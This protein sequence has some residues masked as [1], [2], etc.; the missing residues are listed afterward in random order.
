MLRGWLRNIGGKVAIVCALAL[1]GA[2]AP[3][4]AHDAW[5]KA[6][7]VKALQKNKHKQV[8]RR[9]AAAV[10]PHKDARFAAL[11][12][13][14]DRNVVLYEKNAQAIRYP[15]SLAKMMTLYLVFDAL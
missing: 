7:Q 8:H 4:P 1:L 9:K 3:L 13:D 15:A 6:K 11:L 5:A 14:V 2:A 10:A 12:V